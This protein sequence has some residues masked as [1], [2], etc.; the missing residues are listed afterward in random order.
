MTPRGREQTNQDISLVINIPKQ[1]T[2]SSPTRWSQ[3]QIGSTKQNTLTIKQQAGKSMEK[4]NKQ[5][6]KNLA[7][8]SYKS[9][10]KHT[11][12]NNRT[13]AIAGFGLQRR[14][15][16]F[17]LLMYTMITIYGHVKKSLMPL[18]I[19]WI[20]FLLDLE[21]NFISKLWVFRWALIVLLLLQISWSLSHGK[22]KLT[23]LRLSIQLQD[24][25]I[26]Y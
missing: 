14:T 19:F 3:Y 17:S 9:T 16:F 26:F 18:F 20:I 1:P 12:N 8:S 7:A 23:L 4:K 13:T 10:H 15:C 21:L 2:P 25:L 5:T 22:I 24:T 11:K 6:K